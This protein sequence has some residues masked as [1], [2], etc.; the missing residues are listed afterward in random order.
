[1]DFLDVLLCCL[2]GGAFLLILV[3]VCFSFFRKDRKE[4]T[5]SES[6]VTVRKVGHLKVEVRVSEEPEMSPVDFSDY[7]L[8][9]VDELESGE[10]TDFDRWCDADLP[11]EKRRI[12]AESLIRCGYRLSGWN[13]DEGDVESAVVGS[14]LDVSEAVEKELDMS[15]VSASQE[16]E[17]LD[18]GEA[19]EVEEGF[20]EEDSSGVVELMSLVAAELRAGRVS[21]ELGRLIESNFNLS[22]SKDVWT[23]HAAAS[24][25][26]VPQL[27]ISDDITNMPLHLFEMTVR[28]LINPAE[29]G[30]ARTV[31]H[32]VVTD[33]AVSNEGG[34]LDP[35]WDGLFDEEQ[36]F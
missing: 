13:R 5:V 34:H 28:D 18:F 19:L 22:F 33:R 26:G 6:I 11:Y 36:D 2:A 16:L 29:D 4:E 15:M 3:G 21:A 27:D 30:C 1:M 14:A 31:A 35:F 10:I 12:L 17:S 23:A 7:P 25:E 20:E 9:D 8:G 24:V 32:S